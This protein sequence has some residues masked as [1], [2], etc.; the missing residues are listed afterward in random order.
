[1][2]ETLGI[3]P[4]LASLLRKLSASS[5]ATIIALG[6]LV[7][8]GW[9]FD[10]RFLR[11]LQTSFT[12]KANT[13]L[14]FVVLG[15]GL[16]FRGARVPVR[17]VRA[18][19]ALIA[20]VALTT[21]VEYLFGLELGIDQL[22]VRDTTAGPTD[23]APGRMAPVTSICFL[24]L[25]L[26]L[27]FAPENSRRR[28][29]GSDYLAL[30]SGFIAFLSV[31]GHLYGA[32]LLYK[33]GPYTTMA[34]HTASGLLVA[35]LAFFGARPEQGLLAPFAGD[36]DA[37]GLLRRLLPAIILL[38]LVLGWVTLRAL[39]AGL[40]DSSFG[41]A[42]S[43]VATIA[44]LAAIVLRIEAP[45][46]AA[47]LARRASEDKYRDLYEN[48]PDMYVSINAETGRLIE[49]NDTVTRIMGYSKNELLG[50]VVFELSA[51][52]TI[53]RT[54]EAF[55]IFLS[56][57][58]VNDAELVYLR[59]DGSP[60]ELS[61]NATAV[62]DASGRIVRSRSVWRDISAR[63]EADRERKRMEAELA[64]QKATAERLRERGRFFELSVDMVCIA[65]N[66]GRFLE[67]NPMFSTTLGYS[68]QYLLETPFFE[69]V[70]PDDRQATEREIQS[71]AGGAPTIEFTNRF[72]RA[73]GSYRWLQWR[74]TPESDGTLYAVARDVTRDRQLVDELRV[75]LQEVHHRVKNN[76]QVISSLINMQLRKLGDSPSRTALEECR[77]RVAAIALIHESLHQAKD[78]SR[79]PFSEY[80]RS[81]AQNVFDAAGTSPNNVELHV[82]IEATSLTVDKA[83]PCGL[84]L[85]ELM[86]NALKHA[87][88]G[89][90]HGS[91]HVELKKSGEEQ[92]R[93]TVRD[94]GVGLPE[95]HERGR[96]DS[97]GMV[98]VSALVRQLEG[99]LEIARDGGTAFHVLFPQ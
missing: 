32:P 33:I 38:P 74:S 42:I 92:L 94:D 8:A 83:V 96:S 9:I 97:L 63:K 5:S 46:R 6:L 86:T 40:Y 13:S 98:L 18:C 37:G 17:A 53:E 20:A 4:R 52:G 14:L 58:E 43:T 56:T 79:V 55:Q 72:R 68:T 19:A 44:L 12:M 30:L 39:H 1:M 50:K 71:L 51:P 34:I 59:K 70:H 45:L 3:N 15:V 80:A 57:G 81:L 60:L 65:D 22:L 11:D 26:A 48:A 64:E 41:V 67:L 21:G 76:L 69:L 66:R 29:A 91:I 77:N 47:E 7:F 75:L 95:E 28:G 27:L 78:Y 49:C 24:L 2:T 84:I 16:W 25:G 89:D 87:F 23:L 61:L 36:T 93:L 88:P 62:R 85:N 54:R 31:C 73:D 90:R 10:V 35:T 99:K 82:D